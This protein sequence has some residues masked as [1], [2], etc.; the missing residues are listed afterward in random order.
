MAAKTKSDFEGEN[1]MKTKE[2]PAQI[3]EE[4]ENRNEQ[5]KLSDEEL[6]QVTGG[7]S[8]EFQV[9]YRDNGT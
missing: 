6:L 2:E 5:V 4:T 3:K 1:P 9:A 8:I 7:G